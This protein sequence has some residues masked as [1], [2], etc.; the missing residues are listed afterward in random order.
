M[1]ITVLS[2]VIFGLFIL[3]FYFLL[4]TTVFVYLLF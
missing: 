1:L 2:A 3:F 4:L